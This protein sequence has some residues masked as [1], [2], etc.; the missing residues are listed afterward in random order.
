MPETWRTHAVDPEWER[1]LLKRGRHFG[2]IT[3]KAGV[4]VEPALNRRIVDLDVLEVTVEENI[5]IGG[6][7]EQ[8]AR[9]PFV[10]S[11]NLPTAEHRGEHAALVQ[12]RLG[13]SKGQLDDEVGRDAMWP[14]VLTC[15]PDRRL[16]FV[17]LH[18]P[19][20]AESCRCVKH[21]CREAIGE[22]AIE[23]ELER[24]RS[25][26]TERQVLEFKAVPARHMREHAQQPMPLDGW[27]REERVPR[28]L[29]VECR[30][31]SPQ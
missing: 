7:L 31:R 2:R 19:G 26:L 11:A 13:V 5:R 6:P 8:R 21:I 12:K 15:L 1:A 22:S 17:L 30:I 16:T 24:V 23:A 28:H 3:F 4:D 10:R 29:V 18:R 9:L 25:V 20:F 14:S 27:A